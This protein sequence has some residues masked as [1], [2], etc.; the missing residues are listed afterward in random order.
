MRETEDDAVIPA[1]TIIRSLYG[2]VGT[3]RALCPECDDV[4]FVRHGEMACCG[5][6]V[7]VPSDSERPIIRMSQPEY[8]RRLPSPDERQSILSE[9]NYRCFWCNFPFE[10]CAIKVR[11]WKG[12]PHKPVPLVPVWDHV[13]PF[14]WCSNNNP[15]NFVAACPV[16]NRIKGSKMFDTL[17][18][19]RRYI[20][21]KRESRG[22][23]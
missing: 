20:L 19:C 4:A 17:D 5:L 8:R 13:E 22:W 9:Q 11:E 18:E 21:Q 12:S 1:V 10:G 7:D 14:A 3:D 16:C 2:S 15:L 23:A 6:I